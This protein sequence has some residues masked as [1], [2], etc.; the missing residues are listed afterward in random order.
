MA[1]KIIK[2]G[3]GDCISSIAFNYGI[4][5]WK[6]LYDHQEQKFKDSRK[7]PNSLVVGDQIKIPQ[8]KELSDSKSTGTKVKITVAKAKTVRLRLVII[9]REGK[10]I[11][12][13][14]YT[15]KWAVGVLS[16]GTKSGKTNAQ[17]LI[18]A[19]IPPNSSIAELKLDLTTPTPAAAAAPAPANDP[20]RYPPLIQTE[21]FCKTGE[22]QKREFVYE[23]KLSVGSLPSESTD[24]GII[25]RL[26][27]LGYVC[28]G[29]ELISDVVKTFQ[30]R[31]KLNET[32]SIADVRDNVCNKH[33]KL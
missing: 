13:K 21:N 31:N 22:N 24:N 4:A 25:A 28:V 15:F 9:D 17:G 29:G 20:K 1:D 7:N 27:N 16:W 19:D 33:D 2:V 5:E 23:W 3:E 10:P 18:E 6:K 12:D 8:G 26:G 30:K 32:G 11:N 14:P